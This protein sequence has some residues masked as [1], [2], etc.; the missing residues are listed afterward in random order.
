M[1]VQSSEMI[2]DLIL[3][4][5]SGGEFFVR[6]VRTD[7]GR[8]DVATYTQPESDASASGPLNNERSYQSQK[9]EN[10]NP[11]TEVNRSDGCR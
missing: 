11:K 8:K 4:R 3:L 7:K 6:P 9:Y 5:R 2:S 10:N 1:D